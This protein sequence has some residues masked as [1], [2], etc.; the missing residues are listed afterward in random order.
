LGHLN[1][2]ESRT[3]NRSSSVTGMVR[4]SS[5]TSNGLVAKALLPGT[6]YITEWYTGQGWEGE[7]G[8]VWCDEAK[9]YVEIGEP[10][11]VRLTPVGG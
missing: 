3:G 5:D 7:G 10:G 6:E 4:R 8:L 11:R 1:R 2:V 9:G